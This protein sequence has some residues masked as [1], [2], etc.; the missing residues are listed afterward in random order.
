MD[1][2][3]DARPC[4]LDRQ[5]I[6][7]AD[8]RG[9]GP[10]TLTWM[11]DGAPVPKPFCSIAGDG[12]T[13]LQQAAVRAERLTGGSIRIV[14]GCNH[15][16]LAEKQLND[17]PHCRFVTQP[18]DRGTGMG[19]LLALVDLMLATPDA[20]VVVLPADNGVSDDEVLSETVERA[21]EMT[22]NHPGR[23]VLLAAEAEADHPA[24]DSGWLVTEQDESEAP[25]RIARFVDNPD[26]ATAARLLAATSGWNTMIIVA[27]ARALLAL[28]TRRVPALVRMLFRHAAMRPGDKALFLE[29]AYDVLHPIDLSADILEHAEPLWT[30]KLPLRAGWSNL[31]TEGR[32]RAWQRSQDQDGGTS[33]LRKGAAL[34]GPHVGLGIVAY[35]A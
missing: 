18:R 14:V 16:A 33:G 20:H 13:L 24:T 27:S 5:A 9:A 11:L 21:F 32:V 17:H 3:D 25:R 2:N 15:E 10:A 23:V 19:L 12:V 26:G 6:I 34:L 35:R 7:L 31:G 4:E 1:D 8:R 29:R 28:F 22:K 30:L